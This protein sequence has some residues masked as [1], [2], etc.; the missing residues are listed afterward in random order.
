MHYCFSF[1]WLCTFTV[2]GYFT[3]SWLVSNN[4]LVISLKSKTGKIT[5]LS[6]L[7]QFPKNWLDMKKNFSPDNYILMKSN[8]RKITQQ[9]HFWNFWRCWNSKIW[10]FVVLWRISICSCDLVLVVKELNPLTLP[11]TVTEPRES[12]FKI[13]KKNTLRQQKQKHPCL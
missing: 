11:S 9:T 2:V 4:Y 13:T 1:C 7:P 3:F 5:I 6:N 10:F 12:T 8:I